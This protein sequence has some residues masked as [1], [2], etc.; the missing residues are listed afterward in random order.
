MEHFLELIHLIDT[1]IKDNIK[2]GDYLKLM[3]I[4]SQIYKNKESKQKYIDSSDDEADTN[5]VYG[6][7]NDIYTD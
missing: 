2:E 3:L 6:D 4:I 1:S 7:Y 5:N